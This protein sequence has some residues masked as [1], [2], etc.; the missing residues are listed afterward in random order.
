[1]TPAGWQTIRLDGLSGGMDI[2]YL[3]IK[4]NK[5]KP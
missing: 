4:P 5:E 2:K 1:M 3:G